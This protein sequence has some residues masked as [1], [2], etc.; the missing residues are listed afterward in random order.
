MRRGKLPPLNSLRAF[1]AAGRLESF[2][3]AAE[4]LGVTDGAISRHINQLEEWLGFNLFV[5]H[6]RSVELTEDGTTYLPDTVEALDRLSLA[7]SRL[8]QRREHTVI[9]VNAGVTFALRWLIPKLST[10]QRENPDIEIRI[11]SSDEPVEKVTT[12]FDV[13]IRGGRKPVEGFTD[14]EFL[15]GGYLPFCSPAVLVEKPLANVRDLER[16]TIIHVVPFREAWDEWLCGAGAANLQ[17][18]H[19]LTFDDLYLSIQAAINGMGVA[20]GPLAFIASEL[21][22][23]NLVTPLSGPVLASWRSWRYRAFIAEG[24]SDE[25]AVARFVEWLYAAGRH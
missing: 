1:D 12:P 4:E 20:I 10:F 6:H 5:R 9:R 11:Q 3:L 17:P 7:T 19:S 16:H 14:F 21:E 13:A 24:R 2:R 15:S 22:E 23:G 25:T 8:L 18:L